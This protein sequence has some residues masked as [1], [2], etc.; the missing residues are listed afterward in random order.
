MAMGNFCYI[1]NMNAPMQLRWE[2]VGMIST[3]TSTNVR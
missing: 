3:Q 2:P 1:Q